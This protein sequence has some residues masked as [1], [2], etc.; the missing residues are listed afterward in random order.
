MSI[1]LSVL[2]FDRSFEVAPEL[3]PRVE[4]LGYR[5][6]WF[7]EHPPQANAELFAALV[8][9]ITSDL[10]VG[11]GGVLLRLRN[12]AQSA[13][14]F[15]FLVE[16]FGDRID[17]GFCA[18]LPPPDISR[19]LV[20]PALPPTDDEYEQRVDSWVAHL[21]NDQP[22]ATPEIWS[23]GSGTRSAHSA[24]AL[25]LSFAYSLFH[26]RGG[27]DPAVAT[28]YRERFRPAVEHGAPRLMIA[29]AGV[30]ARTDDAAATR[31]AA[32][33]NDMLKPTLFGSVATCAERLAQVIESYR[34]DELILH[35]VSLSLSEK[36]E[37]YELWMEAAALA[38]R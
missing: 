7:G 2:D 11:T 29:L 31:M 32:F 27:H 19:P 36:C 4:K 17:A 1:P 30:C 20:A 38:C 3:A 14:N 10:R 24:A 33:R 22:Q 37:S 6:Y 23:L 18:G 21:R 13:S 12:P 15:R 8:A 34:P 16:T 26:T 5:R 9:G 28:S 35:D 25:G